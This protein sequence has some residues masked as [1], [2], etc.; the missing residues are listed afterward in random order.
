MSKTNNFVFWGL[1]VIAWLIFVGLSIE[2]GGLIVNFF[3]S[4]FKP[5]FVGN[6]Y[7]KLDLIQMYKESR[8]A[9]FGTYSFILILSISKA[10]LFYI[11]IMLMHKMDRLKPFNCFVSR[12]ISLIS[13]F[14]L[15]IGLLSYI[16]SHLVNNLR[17]HGFV[18]DNINQFWVDSEAFV[19]MGAV[20][21][22][23]ATIFKKGVEIQS[24]NDLTV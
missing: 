22:I 12:Q 18:P 21:Y 10:C 16:A 13:Y 11:V 14:T 4:L 6:L 2:A 3:F 19:L 8:L 15:S 5:E 9:F 7:Q 1:Y 23:I 24:E 17:H 20:V